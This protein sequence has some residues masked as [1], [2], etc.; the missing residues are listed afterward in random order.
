M[1]LQDAVAPTVPY[2]RVLYDDPGTIGTQ[3]GICH[4]QEQ[5]EPSVG[6]P[7]VYSSVAFRPRPDGQIKLGPLL[8]DAQTC[9][10]QAEPNRCEMLNALFGGGPVLD[11]AFPSTMVTFF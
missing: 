6:I 1:P 3:C 9:N 5:A 4:Y 10:W 7:N 11:G 8:F 2:Q